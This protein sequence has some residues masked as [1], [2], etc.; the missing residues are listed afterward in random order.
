[1]HEST[2][3]L[4]ISQRSNSR[5]EA[6]K[7]ASISVFS[8]VS[9]MSAGCYTACPPWPAHPARTCVG[10]AGDAR[11][12]YG[13]DRQ[14]RPPA[15][16][17]PSVATESADEPPGALGGAAGAADRLCLGLLGGHRLARVACLDRRFALRA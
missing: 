8:L 4:T 5:S 10:Y 12:R 2:R 11:V 7:R 1:M 15:G 14:V 13:T 16:A 6:A 17:A 9:T 3:S